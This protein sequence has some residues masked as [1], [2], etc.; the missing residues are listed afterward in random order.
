VTLRH[1]TKDLEALIEITGASPEAC[2]L[3]MKAGE[4][5]SHEKISGP[6]NTLLWGKGHYQSWLYPLVTLLQPKVMIETGV[7]IGLSTFQILRAMQHGEGMFDSMLISIEVDALQILRNLHP[8]LKAPQWVPLQ[9][10]TF[11]RIA[12]TSP[13]CKEMG[14][15]PYIAK[16]GLHVDIF[17]H[18]SDHNYETQKLEYEWAWQHANPSGLIMSDDIYWGGKSAWEE[19]CTEKGI[20]YWSLGSMAV[21][22]KT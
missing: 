19:F 18:D 13:P 5:F 21:A 7:E 12:P 11:D 16:F 14:V 2:A 22:R 20:K 6:W 10:P 17:L 8:V 15:L 9:G 4:D 1:D 3:L